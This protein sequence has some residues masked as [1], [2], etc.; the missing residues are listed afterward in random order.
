MTGSTEDHGHILA[1]EK[2]LLNSLFRHDRAFLV[3]VLA[4]NFIE[5][6]KSGRR[7]NKTTTIAAL[8]EEGGA[9][10]VPI[11]SLEMEDIEFFQLSEDVVL[12]AYAL[13]SSQKASDAIP[14]L[15]S[16]VWRRINL[17]WQLV[18]HQGTPAATT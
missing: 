13:K 4:D 5:F 14:T 11:K 9:N 3:S 1:L 18:F 7:Y 15:R 12:L 8:L 10:A 2:S 16:S 6:G 17:N